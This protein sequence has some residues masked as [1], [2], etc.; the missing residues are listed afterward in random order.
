MSNDIATSLALQPW[1][2]LTQSNMELFSKFALSPEV[3]SEAM[4]A[5]QSLAEQTWSSAASL[6]KSHAVQELM[7][8][9]TRNYTEFATE[10]SQ[11]AYAMMAQAQGALLQQTQAATS[12]VID[13]ATARA[14]RSRHTA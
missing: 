10:L 8:G 9:L 5:M 7:Q 14:G 11:S 12:N 1:I 3:T 2:K 13:A 4:R 6:G